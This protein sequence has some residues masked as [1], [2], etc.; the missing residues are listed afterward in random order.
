MKIDHSKHNGRRFAFEVSGDF[1]KNYYNTY[2]IVKQNTLD[3][4][5]ELLDSKPRLLTL[6]AERG[7]ILGMKH[8]NRA[9]IRLIRL[10]LY[11]VNI[12]QIWGQSA[13]L[14]TFSF[15]DTTPALVNTDIFYRID[16]L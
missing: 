3:I 8:F 5:L 9:K 12:V 1:N 7:I 10:S 15:I 4:R 14:R 13:V 16:R 6:V 11:M 2:I